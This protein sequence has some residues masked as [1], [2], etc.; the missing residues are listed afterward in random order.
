MKASAGFRAL[1]EVDDWSMI[2]DMLSKNCGF[3]SIFLILVIALVLGSVAW[4]VINLTTLARQRVQTS[5]HAD[6]AYYGAEAQLLS[7]LSRLDREYQYWPPELPYIDYG[8]GEDY[9]WYRTI[10]DLED[11]QKW[12]ITI[13]VL[14]K[15]G[16][17][18]AM[19]GYFEPRKQD[20]LDIVLVF[21]T[22]ITMGNLDENNDMPID[23]AEEAGRSF[24]ELVASR[25]S[26]AQFGVVTFGQK[27]N[28][29]TS[30]SSNYQQVTDKIDKFILGIDSNMD[31]GIETA[32]QLLEAGRTD[33][34]K[35]IVIFSDGTANLYGT[36]G[37]ENCGLNTPCWGMNTGRFPNDENSTTGG[38]NKCTHEAFLKASNFKNQKNKIFAVYLSNLTQPD[39]TD[40]EIVALA[41][42][43]GRAMMQSISSQEGDLG[44]P[45]EFIFF[46]E[47]NSASELPEI[48]E[49]IGRLVTLPGF[50]DYSEVEPGTIE[51]DWLDE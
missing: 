10:E 48:F 50:F 26:N 18:R 51:W 45:E 15:N 49:D 20:P 30:L 41:E 31:S 9:S 13:Q 4:A 44:N 5:T 24:V 3:T 34:R 8:E 32:I 39:Q 38:G 40:C 35:L 19:V 37:S 6:R 23:L 25:N 22:F 28:V 12:R 21:N 17:Q 7:S 2:V 16:T 27:G 46:R 33:A 42:R 11:G 29:V 43:L 47:A 1:A 36:Q 14:Q